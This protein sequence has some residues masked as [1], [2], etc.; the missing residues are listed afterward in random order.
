MD[1][2]TFISTMTKAI[3]W[4]I[5]LV[6]LLINFRE[7][8]A[9]I[10]TRLVKA[11]GFGGELEFAQGLDKAEKL[12]SETPTL[13]PPD[14]PSQPARRDEPGLA[15]PPNNEEQ[16]KPKQ[17]SLDERMRKFAADQAILNAALATE[18]V[19]TNYRILKAWNTLEKALAKAATMRNPDHAKLKR[20][21][22]T[23]DTLKELGFSNDAVNTLL[24]LRKLRD[25][26]AYDT[27]N[28][29]SETDALRYE[30]LVKNALFYLQINLS[31]E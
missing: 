15:T 6:V 16:L 10:L 26:A 27:Q 19:P 28:E 11:K 3:A 22:L 24:E 17:P 13:P 31:R 29:V 20:V 23:T 12:A 1:W 5:A 2:L 4:P 8:L 18:A 25:K 21:P 7:S 30:D 9:A 14:A